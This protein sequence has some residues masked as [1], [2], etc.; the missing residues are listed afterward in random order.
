[1]ESG[2]WSQ[3]LKS[4]KLTIPDTRYVI[5]A[6]DALLDPNKRVLLSK[7]D[8]ANGFWSVP[9]AENSKSKTAFTHRNRQYVYYRLPQGFCN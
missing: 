8:L 4:N 9:L 2:G 5:N 3:T 7:I 1:M 6:R